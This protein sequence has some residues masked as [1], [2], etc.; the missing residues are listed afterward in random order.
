[1]GYSVVAMRARDCP[2]GSA[3]KG[4]AP[5]DVLLARAR[6]KDPRAIEALHARFAGLVLMRIRSRLPPVLRVRYDS[7]DIA[8]SVIAELIGRLDTFEDRGEAAF[9]HWLYTVAEQKIRTKLRRLRDARGM[10]REV[11]LS[12]ELIDSAC[13]PEAGPATRVGAAE[14]R[15]QVR[16]LVGRIDGE[17]RE[18]IRLRVDEERSFAEI[19]ERLSLPTADAARMRFQRVVARLRDR[20][21]EAPGD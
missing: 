7:T 21:G 9:R 6:R 8:Q 3:G 5:F 14:E 12:G 20:W 16:E 13:S 4:S 2:D 17:S 15:A 1:M 10:R 11:G 18:L 19:A